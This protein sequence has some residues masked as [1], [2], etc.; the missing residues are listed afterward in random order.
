MTS[1]K[2]RKSASSSDT[3]RF[4]V[5][6]TKPGASYSSS[7]VK[8]ILTIRGTSP[9]SCVVTRDFAIKS[10]SS[11]NKTTDSFLQYSN[12]ILKFEADSPKYDES[13][14]S[15]RTFNNG[16]PKFQAILS[17]L[18]VFPHPGGP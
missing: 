7:K 4:V 6:K 10:H 15:K 11:S 17:A 5:A 1:S 16:N 9:T 3:F 12:I 8:S 13:N 2:R 18:N 14:E